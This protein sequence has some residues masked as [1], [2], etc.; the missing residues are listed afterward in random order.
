MKLTEIVRINE[1]G[2]IVIPAEIRDGVGIVEGMHVLLKTDLER[3]EIRIVPF[4]TA[5]V[6]LVEFTITL[7]DMPGALGK[8]ATFLGEH[9]INMMASESRILQSGEIAE[10]I[11]VADI[12]KCEANI[13]DLCKRIVDE[14]YAKNS[15]CRSFQ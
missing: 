14:G 1:K 13:R 15:I 2:E 11:I 12:S 9:K 10:W 6:D 5:E 4:T 8:C 3:R 7:A